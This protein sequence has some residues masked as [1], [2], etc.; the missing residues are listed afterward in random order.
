MRPSG[1]CVSRA[2]VFPVGKP[3]WPRRPSLSGAATSADP[4]SRALGGRDGR[5]A[6]RRRAGPKDAY[7]A[8]SPG[9]ILNSEISGEEPYAAARFRPMTCATCGASMGNESLFCPM[10]GSPVQVDR[11]SREARKNVT[12]L[13]IDIVGST[14][15][16]E[17]L[18]PEPLRQLLDRYFAACVSAIDEHGGAVEKFIGDAVLAVFGAAVAHEDDAVRAVRAAAGSLAALHA[19][20]ADVT[21]S[22]G[23]RLEARCGLC[24]GEVVVI[25]APGRDFRAVGDAV[26]TASRLQNAAQPGEILIGAQTA[27]MVRG[28]VSIEPIAELRLKGKASAVPAWRVTDAVLDEGDA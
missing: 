6:G 22:H 13:F 24:S 14:A 25:T 15:L 2:A 23:V 21:A 7:P 18:D 4:R 3:Q 20:N 26:N 27:A 10:C 19:L 5:P 28:H 17:Q 12:V 16:A 1:Q 9:A 8:C 11:V